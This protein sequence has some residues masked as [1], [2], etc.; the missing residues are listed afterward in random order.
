MHSVHCGYLPSAPRSSIKL[1]VKSLV[2]SCGF[3][4][5]ISRPADRRSEIFSRERFA[6]SLVT[7]AESN[8]SCMILAVR[9]GVWHKTWSNCIKWGWAINGNADLSGFDLVCDQMGLNLQSIQHQMHHVDD[10]VVG[11]YWQPWMDM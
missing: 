6:F 10:V 5:P 11:I 7:A 9:A 2:R 3:V 8:K 4:W 1:Q